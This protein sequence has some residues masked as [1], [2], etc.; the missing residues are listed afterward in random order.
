MKR[1][2]PNRATLLCVAVIVM[3]MG[4]IGC[5]F[6]SVMFPTSYTPSPGGSFLWATTLPSSFSAQYL[7]AFPDGSC[8]VFGTLAGP[9]TFAPSQSNETTLTPSHDEWPPDAVV[10][11]YATDGTFAWAKKVAAGDGYPTRMRTRADGS[12]VIAG[13]VYSTVALDPGQPSEITLATQEYQAPFLANFGSN[14]ILDWAKLVG[15]E[16]VSVSDVALFQDGSFLVTGSFRGVATFGAGELNATSFDAAGG[17][18]IFL[19]KY[20]PDGGLLWATAS[21][22]GDDAAYPVEIRLGGDGSSLML[23]DFSGTLTL[24]PGEPNQAI[25]ESP[26][27][28]PLT[29]PVQS[30]FVARFDE[31]G[32]FLWAKIP[33]RTSGFNF[34]I[35]MTLDT[36]PDGGWFLTG[37]FTGNVVLGEG[38]ANRTSLSGPI[39]IPWLFVAFESFV[40]KYAPDGTLNWARQTSGSLGTTLGVGRVAADGS[41]V[42]VGSFVGTTTLNAGR[43]GA[44][45]IYA[46]DSMTS[47]MVVAE[48]NS[49]GALVWVRRVGGTVGAAAP[50]QGLGV[51]VAEEDGSCLVLGGFSTSAVVG[52]GEPNETELTR[53]EQAWTPFIVKFPMQP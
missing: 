6:F 51:D 40:A 43:P 53:P 21:A 24:G 27:G 29:G 14:G 50:T 8:L 20:A 17:E 1:L 26:G 16:N 15:G 18:G 39:P 49:S 10:A 5:P 11:R 2:G 30:F 34:L 23:G 28:D 3:A 37:M 32:R 52:Y 47:D 7:E 35:P 22:L 44:L 12:F 19:A 4:A 31:A 13:L 25:L 48:Y 41:Y 46:A 9:T 33:A 36:A 38:E 42:V 45:Q